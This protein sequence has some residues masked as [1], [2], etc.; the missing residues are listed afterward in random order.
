VGGEPEYFGITPA[1][2]HQLQ[3]ARQ[4]AWPYQLLTTST[5]DTKRSEDVRARIDVLSEMPKEWRAAV[6]RW[7]RMNHKYKRG[8]DG[9]PA[10]G[11]NEEYF[12]YQTLVGVWPFKQE[13]DDIEHDALTERM[14]AYMRKA[15]NEAKVNTSWVNVNEEY[16]SAVADFLLAI[17]RRRRDNRFLAD[18]LPFQARVAHYGAFNSLSQVLVK[19][20]SPGVP[21]IYQGSELWDFSLVD[22]DNRR[23]V[24]YKLRRR[25]LDRIENV[26]DAKGAAVLLDSKEDGRIKLHVTARA[27]DYRRENRALFEQGTYTPIEVEGKHA[28]NIIAYVRQHPGKAALTVAPRLLTRLAAGTDLVDPVGDVWA[29][30]RLPVPFASPGDRLRN[31]FTGEKLTVEDPG[32]AP[33]LPLEHVLG[34]FPLALLHTV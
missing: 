4:N 34:A 21:D 20:T 27:L 31:V 3:A 1:Q 18:F 23:P 30:A 2:F 32:G 24:D 10:P 19:I 29:G 12:I 16:H 26:K 14:L 5:H 33:S 8:V 28:P 9:A 15:L 6:R 13:L 11:P 22:P 25:L 17:L 7:A